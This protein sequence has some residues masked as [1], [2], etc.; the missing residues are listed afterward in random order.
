MPKICWDGS[1]T[2]QIAPVLT[3]HLVTHSVSVS[4]G[5]SQSLHSSSPIQSGN[6]HSAG[7]GGD[8][9]VI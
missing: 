6:I 9:E 4:S 2:V 5:D 7:G 3:Q 1:K 8:F